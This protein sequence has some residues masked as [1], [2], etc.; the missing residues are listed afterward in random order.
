MP[1]DGR[2]RVCKARNEG[3]ILSGVSILTFTK[4]SFGENRMGALNDF[5]TNQVVYD[6]S[7]QATAIERSMKRYFDE[8]TKIQGDPAYPAGFDVTNEIQSMATSTA[9]GGT[10]TITIILRNGETATTAAIAFGAI[11]S[12]VETAIDT[13]ITTEITG[14]TNGDISVSGGAVNVAPVVFTYD[15]TSVAGQKI[16]LMTVDGALLTGGSEGAVTVT[17]DGQ[18]TRESWAVLRFINVIGS[19][20]PP[21]QGGVVGLVVVGERGNMQLQPNA[22]VLNALALQCAL[23]D[24]VGDTE[25]AAI[26]FAILDGLRANGVS[27]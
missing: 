17:T 3:S 21:I 10:F 4:T 9:T 6:N 11:A 8:L 5:I 20:T 18:T 19:V 25:I 27:V 13:A 16:V 15:G 1:P 24:G 2:C 23:D 22:D 14:W 12:V 26:E 7:D